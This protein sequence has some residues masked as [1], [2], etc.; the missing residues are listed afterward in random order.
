M[1]E[2]EYTRPRTRLYLITPP[3]IDDVDA[4]AAILETAFSA[5]DIA[6]CS[7]A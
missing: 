7:C 2:P 1:S 6:V 4:F 3:R 5:G